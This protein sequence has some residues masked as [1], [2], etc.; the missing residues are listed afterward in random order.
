MP[1]KLVRRP[2]K[3]IGAAP[4]T[5]VFTGEKK[6]EKCR[7]RVIDYNPQQLTESEIPVK[8]VAQCCPLKDTRSVSWVNVDGLHQIKVIETLGS[9]YGLHPLVMEDL[10]S[11]EQRPKVEDYESYLF[12]VIRMLSFDEERNEI[13][14]EQVS[15]ILGDTYVISFQEVEGDVFDGVRERIRSGQG[16]IRKMGPDYLA[17][18]LLDSVVDS[19]FHIL[20]RIGDQ[21]EQLEDELVTDPT[22]ETLHKIHEFK[23]EMILLRKSI[24]PLREVLSGLQRDETPLVSAATGVFFR[25]VYDHTIQVIDTVETL[26]DIIAGQLDLYLSSISNRM[27]EV[28]KV[29][30]IIATIFI[31]LT[32]VAGIYGMNFE[33]M[34]ELHWRWGYFAVWGLMLGMGGLMFLFFRKKRWL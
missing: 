4:G 34:P 28:M 19:Y 3:K 26:R 10:L 31:P 21:I 20:E 33:F 11:T 8:D 24:W 32:F 2:A 29:L 23:R 18:A 1:R 5:L 6:V 30:T 9:C 27:N 14:A 17:Y 7:I 15:L 13:K 22:P 25:D 12:I 16:R